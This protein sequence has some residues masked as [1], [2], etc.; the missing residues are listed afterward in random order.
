M[1]PST[2][3]KQPSNQRNGPREEIETDVK[4]PRR[5]TQGLR[6]GSGGLYAILT[7]PARYEKWGVQRATSDGE[8]G[9]SI[10]R[11]GQAVEIFPESDLRT[12][13]AGRGGG[14]RRRRRGR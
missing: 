8:S 11:Q 5:R 3:L 4:I 13:A 6:G 10:S 2:R 7:A 14:R 12:A 1:Y 9:E